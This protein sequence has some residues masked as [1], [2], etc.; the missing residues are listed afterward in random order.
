MQTLVWNQNI[1][2]GNIESFKDAV[3]R[4]LECS[5]RGFILNLDCVSYMNSRALGIIAN[6]AIEAKKMSKE[7]VISNIG[8]TIKEIFKIVCFHTI[9]R[10]FVN[11][12]DAKKYFAEKN[13]LIVRG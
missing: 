5:A 6:A 7:L 12:D 13:L 11:E 4:L 3:Q 9:I 10:V 1:S 8:S 2:M